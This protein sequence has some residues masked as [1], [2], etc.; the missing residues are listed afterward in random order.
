MH[1][2]Q[3]ASSSRKSGVTSE[4]EA[5]E[6]AARANDKE[7]SHL[8]STTL[9]APGSGASSSTR[10]LSHGDTAARLA[11]LGASKK[12]LRGAT[13]GRGWGEAK[14]KA[15]DMAAM[16][17]AMRAGMRKKEMERQDK[18]VELAKELGTYHPSLK[19]VKEVGSDLIL[20]TRRLEKEQRTREKGVGMGVGT[21]RNGT[22]KIGKA[23]RERIEGSRGGKTRGR[24]GRGGAAGRGGK[25][26]RA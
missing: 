18:R 12:E 2:S 19:R 14:V 20:G 4:D 22:L 1:T 26:G 23:E 10:G 11:E 16:P 9:F 13:V 17:A 8:L 6:K 3:A 15:Q 25:R 24:G 21:F 5:D 7:L